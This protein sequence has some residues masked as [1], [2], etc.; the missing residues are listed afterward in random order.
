MAAADSSQ[1]INVLFGA[2]AAGTIGALYKGIKEFREGSWRRKDSAVADLERWRRQ[3][4]DA[5][6]WEALQHQWWRDYAGRLVFV[7]TSVL[8]PEKLPKKPPYP[9]HPAEG[10]EE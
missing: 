2:G 1:W 7:I 6:E 5:R 9:K 8:G 3:A 10:D 4:D